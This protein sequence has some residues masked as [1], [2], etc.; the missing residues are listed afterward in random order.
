VR[1]SRICI[2]S[3][4]QGF[5]QRVVARQG[6]L[7]FGQFLPL[8]EQALG[9]RLLGRQHALAQSPGEGI[10]ADGTGLLEAAGLVQIELRPGTL[11]VIDGHH[12]VEGRQFA[13]ANALLQRDAGNAEQMR[14]AGDG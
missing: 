1:C 3:G 13:V 7:Q 10:L 9:Q 6:A 5:E 4:A 8:D 12:A 2:E 14:G 11:H